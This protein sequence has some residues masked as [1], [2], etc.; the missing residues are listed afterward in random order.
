MPRLG[1]GAWRWRSSRT[2]GARWLARCWLEHA[3]RGADVVLDDTD[4]ADGRD[5]EPLDHDLAALLLHAVIGGGEGVDDDVAEPVRGDAGRVLQH[6]RDT[7]G[8]GLEDPHG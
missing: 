8:A 3:D 2:V 7:G 1:G 4:R 6:R 5:V